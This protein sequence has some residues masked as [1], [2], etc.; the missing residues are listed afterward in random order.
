MQRFLTQRVDDMFQPIAGVIA[1]ASAVGLVNLDKIMIQT[2][3]WSELIAN[4][5]GALTAIGSFIILCIKLKG[6]WERVKEKRRRSTD[7]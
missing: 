5:F 1:G 7:K 4:L 3:E 6:Y 2:S